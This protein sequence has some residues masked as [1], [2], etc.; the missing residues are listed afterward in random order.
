MD[1]SAE[2]CALTGAVARTAAIVGHTSTARRSCVAA[3]F[4]ARTTS[5]RPS[6]PVG[7]ASRSSSTRWCS[8]YDQTLSA[9][10]QPAAG[11]LFQFRIVPLG[12]LIACG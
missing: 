2:A 9:D 11:L 12:G 4:I 3:T 5:A 8:W 7:R 1:A 10:G 6:L